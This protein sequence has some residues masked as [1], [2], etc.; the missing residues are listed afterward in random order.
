MLLNDIKPEY[1]VYYCAALLIKE[2][3]INEEQ[4]ILTLYN[5]IKNKYDISLKIFA[6]SL[7]WLYLIEAA[8]VNEKGAISLCT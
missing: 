8:T 3:E 5:K 2:I 1:S 4:D 7:D 6:Y